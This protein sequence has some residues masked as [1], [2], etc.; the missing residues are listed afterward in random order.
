MKPRTILFLAA[1]PKDTNPLRL[2]QELREIGEGLKRA[3]HRD[4]FKLQQQV[5]TRPIDIRRALLDY[6]PQIVHFSGHGTGTEGL[7]FEDEQGNAKL[8]SGDAIADL[9]RLFSD[10]LNCVVLNGC[11][12]EIQAKAISKHIPFVIGMNKAIGDKAAIAF[13]VGFYDALSAG[14]DVEFAFEL[15]CSAIQ[16][17][18]IDEHLIPVLLAKSAVSKTGDFSE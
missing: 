16:M 9:F 5:A 13:S 11:Y 6:N 1:N 17:E 3:Q 12:T 7:V 8:V 4:L 14:R 18:G 10:Q 2:D 15:G